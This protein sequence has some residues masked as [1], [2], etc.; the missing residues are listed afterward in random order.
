[1]KSKTLRALW[2]IVLSMVFAGMA[3]QNVPINLDAGWNWISYPRSEAMS[4]EEALGGLTPSQG[5]MIKGM[6]GTSVYQNGSWQGSLE[7]LVPGKGY[8]YYC[9]DGTSKSFVFG[10]PDADPSAIPEAALDG[11]FTV[12]AN[13]TTVRFSPG[14]LQCRIDPNKEVSATIGTATMG[15]NYM[16]FNTASKYSLCQFIITGEE[17]RE[18]GLRAGNIT[19]IA[20]DASVSDLHYMRDGIKIWM[21][22]TNLTE[23]PGTSVLTEGMT[24][25]FEGSVSQI[26]G[27]T[28]IAFN[29]GAFF[30]NGTSNVI[31]TIVMNHGS[32]S[33]Y[34]ISWRGTSNQ[35]T[36]G[37]GYL[38]RDDAPF[39]P[40]STTYT[41]NTT[42]SR[43]VIRFNGRGGVTWRFAEKQWDYIGS[44]N[45]NVS[46][47]YLG[48]IDLFGWGTSG[49]SHGAFC[50]QPWSVSKTNSDYLAYG[51]ANYNLFDQTGQADWGCNPISNGGNSPGQWRTMTKSEWQYVINTRNTSSGIR[52]AKA[53][54]GG[55][56]GV[57]L[58][59][60]NWNTSYYSLN[61]TN[62]TGANFTSNNL[63]A[64]QW[65]TL[66]N[67]GAVF[68]PVAG[69]RDGTSFYS[70]GYGSYWASTHYGSTDAYSFDFSNTWAST[71][72]TNGRYYGNSVRL[73]CQ[74]NPRLRIIGVNNVTGTAATVNVT[75]DY[76]GDVG[77]R[78][79][80][81]NT[82]GSPI[83]ENN[84]NFYYAG[85]GTGS[86]TG[87][88]TG[89]NES[90]TYH[91]RAYAQINDAF[92][93][94]NEFVFTTKCPL[95]VTI[96][97][98]SNL[99]PTCAFCSG[100]VSD[101]GKDIITRGFCW[102]T[103]NNPSVSGS[104]TCEGTGTGN[105]TGIINGLTPGYTY[106]VKAYATTA[107][108]T[109]YSTSRI[110]KADYEFVDLGLPSGLLWAS[111]NV[112]A[113]TPEGYG[114]FFAWG[115]TSPKDDYNWS[116]Y[117]YCNGTKN[118]LTKY[119]QTSSYGY[120][121]F[122]DNLFALQP[123][124]DAATALWGNGW[125][126]P[127]ENE[128]WELIGNTTQTWTTRNGVEGYLFT[129]SNGNKLFLPAAGWQYSNTIHDR[130]INCCY[131][132]SSLSNNSSIP[133][134]YAQSFHPYTLYG[135]LYHINDEER[136]HG[137][138]V[139][140][141]RSAQ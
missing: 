15:M 1:M 73:V 6:S 116:T 3:A 133:P 40:V 139:R 52:F 76:T 37:A 124:D 50:Y 136:S 123:E 88:M 70:N 8:M 110:I 93:Y 54:I 84:N 97:P 57:I 23:M 135:S 108:S 82:T 75:L 137:L 79:V 21:A 51:S 107:E 27:W 127:T 19:G 131:W 141:V 41:L 90:T 13:G 25:V 96:A 95:A 72:A 12:D 129:A 130:C 104:H 45:A 53:Q 42:T 59:P 118:T 64:A 101:C 122:T 30:W 60:D 114:D 89:L 58:L 49:H 120:N 63:T 86:F 47:A 109:T 34:S 11:E 32:K 92:Q 20:F 56:S 91:V 111:H 16:P 22:A 31:L 48:W 128:W 121:G 28:E 14:N 69:Y 106:Y 80:C 38:Y 115:E 26:T 103:N 9:A 35:N 43:P 132:T 17:L 87:Q 98:V 85:T 99:R 112:G 10:G 140:A 83:V 18:V 117:T 100:S 33:S 68:L 36:Y 67:Y 125:R 81:W 4:L 134:Y 39:D 71:T 24:Q 62:T 5:D 2:T 29:R 102:S 66:E 7:I 61:S 119:C 77:Y 126:I 55:V 74:S 113:E 44:G 46:P 65:K 105:F 138:S 94:S 78:G